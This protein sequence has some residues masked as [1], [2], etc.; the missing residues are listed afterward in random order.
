MTQDRIT[1]Q[2]RIK[3]RLARNTN[4]DLSDHHSPEAERLQRL[5]ITHAQEIDRDQRAGWVADWP[6]ATFVMAPD[7]VSMHAPINDAAKLRVFAV[8]MLQA[9]AELDGDMVSGEFD[10]KAALEAVAKRARQGD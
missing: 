9:A 2:T 7:R 4:F 3:T 10:A 1:R 5:V 6:V 8:M